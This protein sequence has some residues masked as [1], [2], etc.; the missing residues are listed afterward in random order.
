[1]IAENDRTEGL[2]G[3]DMPALVIHG[4]RD[5][6]VKPDGGR[7]TAEA[8]PGAELL[9]IEGM[10]HDLARWTWPHVLDGIERTAARADETSH[11]HPYTG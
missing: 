3:L 2:F 9:E 7:A 10:G 6:I 5:F 8:I 11:A 4:T 1:V